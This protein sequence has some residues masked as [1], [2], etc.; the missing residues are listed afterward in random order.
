MSTSDI[1]KDPLLARMFDR[2]CAAHSVPEADQRAV[3]RALAETHLLFDDIEAQ[4]AAVNEVYR[5]ACDAL[6]KGSAP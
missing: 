4:S 6:D 5:F 2:Y 1:I 3:L